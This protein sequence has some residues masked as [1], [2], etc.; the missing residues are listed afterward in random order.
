M[1]SKLDGDDRFTLKVKR[2]LSDP[3]R[4]QLLAT[5]VVEGPMRAPAIVLQLRSLHPAI[6]YHEVKRQLEIL[7]RA[8]VLIK[9]SVNSQTKNASHYE[10]DLQVVILMNISLAELLLE[11]M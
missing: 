4:R 3:L 6:T 11:T 7:R 8:R 9:A 5:L 1:S 2:L 10:V